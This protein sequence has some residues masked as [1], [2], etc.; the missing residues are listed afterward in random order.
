MKGLQA[1]KGGK[2]SSRK[3]SSESLAHIG[4]VSELQSFNSTKLYGSM[5]SV[6]LIKNFGCPDFRIFFN[7]RFLLVSLCSSCFH[8]S[9]I[10]SLVGNILCTFNVYPRNYILHT[11]SRVEGMWCCGGGVFMK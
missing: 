5:L 9:A 2:E 4:L 3:Q 6:E 8:L 10:E 7:L 11:C 1:R